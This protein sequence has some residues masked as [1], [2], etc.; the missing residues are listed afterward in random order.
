MESMRVCIR[1]I[2]NILTV[3]T[4][5]MMAQRFV[6]KCEKDF[7]FSVITI[8]KKKHRATKEY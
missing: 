2:E 5:P 4:P 6:M 8:C 1:K 3:K 7:G